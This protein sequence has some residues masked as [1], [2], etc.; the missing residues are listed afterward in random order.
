[1]FSFAFLLVTF[2]PGYG[3]EQRV[4][5][6]ERMGNFPSNEFEDKRRDSHMY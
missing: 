4:G 1:M 5:V 3:L 6:G 2:S